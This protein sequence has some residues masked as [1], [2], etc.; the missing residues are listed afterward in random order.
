MR[1]V[2]Q[3]ADKP[4]F[5]YGI[6]TIHYDTVMLCDGTYEGA[7]ETF[8]SR[9][10]NNMRASESGIRE[11]LSALATL[12]K[13]PYLSGYRADFSDDQEELDDFAFASLSRRLSRFSIRYENESR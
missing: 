7:S 12:L 1:P 9:E 2:C 13:Q 6:S 4:A 11:L 8:V 5:L 3:R 10:R